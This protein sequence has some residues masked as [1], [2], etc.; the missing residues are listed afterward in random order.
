MKGCQSISRVYGESLA[1]LVPSVRDAPSGVVNNLV[2]AHSYVLNEQESRFRAT[3]IAT[4]QSDA[5]RFD[6]KVFVTLYSEVDKDLQV[7]TSCIMSNCF[8]CF[9]EMTLLFTCWCNQLRILI[10]LIVEWT[11]V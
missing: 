11:Q 7:K 2:E 9:S 1:L 3:Y 5:G 8:T 10:S 4:V 6:L